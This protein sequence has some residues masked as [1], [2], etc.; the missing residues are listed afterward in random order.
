MIT[1]QKGQFVLFALVLAIVTGMGL[2][3]S[4]APMA[5][6]GEGFETP[7]DI[8]LLYL[9]GFREM[10]LSKM[11]SAFAIETYVNKFDYREQLKLMEYSPAYMGVKYPNSNE[12]LTSINIEMRKNDIVG[13]I[14]WQ[15]L[16][17]HIQLL[18]IDITNDDPIGDDADEALSYIVDTF[19]ESMDSLAVDTLEV[20]GFVPPEFF[21]EDY[22]S[23]ENQAKL[24]K[25]AEICGA[26]EIQSVV[27]SFV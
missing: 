22:R 27:V 12:L 16:Q 20:K 5:Y 8:V 1:K 6:E 19:T 2:T 17:L 14:L 21:S 18:N 24:K 9:E 23:E 3:S 4:A 26:D 25:H 13:V 11:C 15:Q 7:E 10:D